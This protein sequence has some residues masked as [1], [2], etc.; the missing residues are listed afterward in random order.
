MFAAISSGEKD[1]I[2]SGCEVGGIRLDGRGPSN[3]RSISLENNILPHVNGSSRVKISDFTDVICSIKVEL[4][5]ST[6]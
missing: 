2:K 5:I 3:F 6:P 4:L 1:Y